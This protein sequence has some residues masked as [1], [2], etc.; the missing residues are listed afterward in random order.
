MKYRTRPTIV[1]AILVDTLISA[2]REKRMSALPNWARSACQ[3]GSIMLMDD[4]V[5]LTTTRIAAGGRS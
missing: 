3:N 2:F 5:E 4:F 1:E